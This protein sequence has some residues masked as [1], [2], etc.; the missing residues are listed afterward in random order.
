METI[1][2]NKETRFLKIYLTMMTLTMILFIGC[3]IANGIYWNN[4]DAD[5]SIWTLYAVLG[6]IAISFASITVIL[7]LVGLIVIIKLRFVKAL[8]FWYIFVIIL[9]GVGFPVFIF[10]GIVALFVKCKQKRT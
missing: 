7:V 1:I 8:I 10:G 5:E 6:Y 2:N 4:V 3:L 9:F